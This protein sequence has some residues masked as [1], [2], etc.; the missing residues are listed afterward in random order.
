MFD[1][2]S[3]PCTGLRVDLNP[4]PRLLT[5]DSFD[6]LK[7]KSLPSPDIGR[8]G[9]LRH[10]WCRTRPCAAAALTLGPHT[11]K[12]EGN[13]CVAAPSAFG[14]EANPAWVRHGVGYPGPQYLGQSKRDPSGYRAQKKFPF[15]RT[16]V[17]SFSLSKHPA[18]LRIC[19]PIT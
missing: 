10:K 14:A 7:K 18:S 9:V 17:P 16:L 5:T 19:T 12:P 8:F 2:D 4:R 3:T 13:P 11:L 15:L 1:R 6:Q